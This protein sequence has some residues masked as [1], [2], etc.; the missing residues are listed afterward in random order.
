MSSYKHLKMQ[1]Y[2][3]LNDHI[4]YESTK[5]IVRA[6]ESFELRVYKAQL[7]AIN[8]VQIAYLCSQ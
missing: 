4:D 6:R 8:H 7:I 5:Q 3:S 1:V 2:V